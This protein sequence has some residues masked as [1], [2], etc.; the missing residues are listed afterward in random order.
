MMA[1][2]HTE[3][4]PLTPLS[5]AHGLTF[6]WFLLTSFRLDL[7]ICHVKCYLRMVE[8]HHFERKYALRAFSS[9]A[10]VKHRDQ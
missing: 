2:R 3:K 10:P 5:P 4:L 9:D 8:K 7:N 6:T 1:E